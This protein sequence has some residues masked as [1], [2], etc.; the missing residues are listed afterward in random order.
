MHDIILTCKTSRNQHR[1]ATDKLV[2]CREF[3]RSVFRDGPNRSDF[4]K[5]CHHQREKLQ[6]P[7]KEGLHIDVRVAYDDLKHCNIW[8]VLHIEVLYNIERSITITPFTYHFECVVGEVSIVDTRSIA[9]KLGKRGPSSRCN[10]CVDREHKCSF[11][12][13]LLPIKL[14]AKATAPSSPTII[15]WS[16]ISFSEQLSD[17]KKADRDLSP[18]A[19]IDL[20][21]DID[22]FSS[23]LLLVIKP[24][25][26]PCKPSSLIAL[27]EGPMLIH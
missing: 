5:P 24:D 22:K 9:Q 15:S 13:D 7:M 26:K 6:F 14:S 1:H 27:F 20:F 18:A 10:A 19:V 12:S 17:W 16:Q 23:L 8:Y 21:P 11:S 25:T 2:H 4:V 3:S